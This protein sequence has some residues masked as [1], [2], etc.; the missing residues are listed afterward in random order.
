MPRTSKSLEEATPE[1]IARAGLEII[2]TRGAAQLSFRTIA[3]YLQVSHTTVVRRGGGDFS[4]L[5]DLLSDHLA[6]NLPEITPG[7][8]PWAD[9]TQERFAA[10]YTL[11]AAHPGLL[12]LRGT[13][14][15]LGPRLLSRLTEPQVA[16]NILLGLTVTDAFTA[17][18]EM[19]LYTLGCAALVEHW[20]DKAVKLRT[21]SA[22]AALDPEEFPLLSTHLT[23]VTTIITSD[24]P[25]RDGLR[26]L[27]DSWSATVK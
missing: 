17:Y 1:A 26:R 25:F 18:R 2:E 10:W 24:E 6:A 16:D 12:L 27:V 8:K 21:R 13:R 14:P 3:A 5:L 9:A 15:L 19:Y 23:E 22:L 20:N 4:G 11:T 7:S